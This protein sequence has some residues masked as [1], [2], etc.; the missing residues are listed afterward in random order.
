VSHVHFVS[1]SRAVF[2]GLVLI[3][4]YL[5][6]RYAMK[7]SVEN[8]SVKAVTDGAIRTVPSERTLAH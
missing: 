6:R 1:V 8:C 4:L 5:H 3:G 7:H 2:L